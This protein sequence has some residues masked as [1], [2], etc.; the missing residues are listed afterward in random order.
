ML[1]A[2]EVGI[3][4]DE[5]TCR[6][7]RA[8]GHLTVR[9]DVATYPT[10]PFS[11]S[12]LGVIASPPC[13][14]WSLAGTGKG[15]DGTS[16]FLVDEVLRWVG[17]LRPPWVACEQ[18]PPALGVWREFAHVLNGWGYST[19]AGVLNSADYGVP[20]TRERAF[21][22]AHLYAEVAPP[23]P[24]HGRSPAPV[25]FG[26]EL[27]PWVPMASAIG[28]G[29]ADEPAGTI[30]ANSGRQGGS[31]PLDGG[32]GAREKYR[33]AQRQGR[34]LDRRQTGA[35]VVDIHA[36][37]CPTITAAA[38]GKVVWKITDTEGQSIQ[39]T[40]AE[41]LTLQGFR[42]DY[43]VQGPNLKVR[44]G[45]IGN[46]VPPP[47]AAHVLGALTGRTLREDVAA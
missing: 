18:V 17:D 42:P 15:R 6:T 11:A 28:W 13:P 32:T 25:L 38:F 40:E 16:G 33:R 3:E 45:Q 39:I 36:E 7:R 31:S 24:T 9:A 22:L 21:L 27:L 10:D 1:G 5:W 19:W 26:D 41:A 34:W 2:C 8:A 30:L 14:D 23:T 44:H 29:I 12:G 43:P 20:Q 4:W 37:P 46:A 35:P 47:L